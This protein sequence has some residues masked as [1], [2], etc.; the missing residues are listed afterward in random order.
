MMGKYG[1]DPKGST[2][3]LCIILILVAIWMIYF[4]NQPHGHYGTIRQQIWSTLHFPLHLSIV[5]VVEGAQQVALARYM[6]YNLRKYGAKMVDICVN[7]Q[8]DG[9]DLVDA[10]ADGVDYF[11]LDKK[12]DSLPW[13]QEAIAY[14]A[15][16]GNE[17]GICADT[18]AA[19]VTELPEL[20][21]EIFAHTASGFYA[22]LGVKLDPHDGPLETALESWKIVYRYF[23]SATLILLGCF[24]VCMLLIRRNKM[25]F[26]DISSLINRGTALCI[27]A[28]LLGLS[29]SKDFMYGLL[30]TPF[31]LPTLA[32]L[33][34]LIILTDRF[35]AW[36]ANR[37]NRKSGQPLIEEEDHHSHHG[38]HKKG[39][40]ESDR[41]G[42][43]RDEADRDGYGNRDSA[44]E[45]LISKQ[46]PRPMH[47]PPPPESPSPPRQPTARQ[48]LVGAAMMPE[49][50]ESFQYGARPAQP[51]GN[52]QS[53][54]RMSQMLDNYPD[55][56]S[57]QVRNTYRP[58]SN[59]M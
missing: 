7:K 40:D 8:L 11:Q 6:L 59:V 26:F 53:D 20:L 15:Q 47:M 29:A 16:A 1:L 50:P 41:D 32:L 43:D 57:N 28:L 38:H 12:A 22:S 46:V 13:Y 37:R 56:N 5:G 4:D 39:H 42:S 30:E 2:I 19:D 17:A 21:Q 51:P 14:V 24:I 34:Y 44:S 36:M 18:Q 48:S 31:I 9:E 33:L 10:L 49:Y 54:S 23:W 45:A 3:V 55:V 27:A 35:S 52:P 58:Y 25:D